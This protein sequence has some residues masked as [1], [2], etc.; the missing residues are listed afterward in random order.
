M[1]TNLKDTNASTR[2]R[3]LVWHRAGAGVFGLC[4]GVAACS[5]LAKMQEPAPDGPKISALEFLPDHTVAGCPA[6][7]RFRFEATDAGI[8]R[9]IGAWTLKQG[10]GKATDSGLTVFHVDPEAFSGKR[11]GEVSVPLTFKRYGTYWY[12][13]QVE[14]RAG[15]W[16]N[17]MNDAILVEA[18]LPG[19]LSSCQ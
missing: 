15:R 6:K 18:Q 11:S 7:L 14:D 19:Q 13:V 8:V 4:L 17:V 5:P 12:Y 3:Q 1:T 2:R 10:R 16:S 9:A